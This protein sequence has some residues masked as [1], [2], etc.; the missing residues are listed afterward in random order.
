MII[1]SSHKLF[2]IPLFVAGE[3][4]GLVYL[5]THVNRPNIFIDENLFAEVRQY[6]PMADPSGVWHG[7]SGSK[8]VNKGSISDLSC[9]ESTSPLLN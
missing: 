3:G 4:R 2:Y 7:W 5:L 1:I 6:F 9:I 8:Q